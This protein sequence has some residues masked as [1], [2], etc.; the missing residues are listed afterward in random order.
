[1]AINISVNGQSINYPQIGDVNWFDDGTNFAVQTSAALGKIGLSTGT[2]VD[3]PSTLDVSG[4][5]TFDSNLDVIGNVDFGGT[6]D[7]NN[8]LTVDSGVLFVDTV[9]D[10]IGINTLAPSV[11]LE[12]NGD[13]DIVNDLDV[14]NDLAIGNDLNVSGQ[15]NLDSLLVDTNVLVVDSTNNR[16]GINQSTPTK[17]L[18]I[19]GDATISNDLDV[20]NNLDVTGAI[21]FG[22]LEFPDGSNTNP[23]ITF[24]NDSNTGIYRSAD[25]TI[26]IVTNGVSRFRV[27]PTGQIKSVYES[28][29]GTDFNTQLDNGY[30]C[31][32]WVNFDG[33]GTF[34]PNPSSGKIRASGNVSSITDNGTGDYAVNFTTAMPDENYSVTAMVGEGVS[35]ESNNYFIRMAPSGTS[36]PNVNGFRFRTA[37]TSILVDLAYILL[38]VFR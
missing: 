26:D 22:S 10:R 31:R 30:F 34:S 24:E 8:D 27:E 29:V 9:N 28:T 1:M 23:S 2:T 16:V 38:A 3:I 15:T 12:V 11:D 6:V 21:T 17:D 36:N 19:V 25:D 20:G 13:V 35:G 18:D 4:N 7:F 37:N 5:V 32:A 33:T 14:G